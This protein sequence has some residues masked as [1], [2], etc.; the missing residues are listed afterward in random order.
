M[1]RLAIVTG[2]S[3]GIGH[4]V[5]QELVEHGWDVV[6]IARH[7]S[8]MES[9]RYRHL[10]IDLADVDALRSTIVREIGPS[11]AGA[12]WQRIGLV[13]NAA[14][15]GGLGPLEQIDPLQMARMS[16]V[17][18]V[19]PTWLMG[20]FVSHVREDAALRIVNVSSGAA[21]RGFPGLGDYCGSKA[22]LRM[23]TMSLATELDSDLR[24]TPAP[25]DT[26]ILSYEPGTVDTAMQE[27]ARTK[28]LRD[29]P[30]GQLFRDFHTKG[31]LV[32]PSEPAAEI[33]AF[34]EADGQQRFTERR[35]TR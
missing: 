31:A 18:W 3:R 21:V 33:V 13:N 16:V 32:A 10:S 12:N 6:G 8:P 29:Y 19:A 2:T 28:S 5:A 25:R 20:F 7:A 34:L 24:T 27:E 22:A 15:G 4:A 23:T 1:D 11:I 17:N 26:A 30:W 35:F 9:S 14:V